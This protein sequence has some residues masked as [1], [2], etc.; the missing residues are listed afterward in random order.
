MTAARVTAVLSAP[1][2]VWAVLLVVAALLLI[3]LRSELLLARARAEIRAARRFRQGQEIYNKASWAQIVR[4]RRVIRLLL[5]DLSLLPIERDLAERGPALE[6]LRAPAEDL[7][8]WKDAAAQWL[9]AARNP[10]PDLP[11]ALAEP[12]REQLFAARDQVP[13]GRT[14]SSADLRAITA[15]LVQSGELA[16]L[17]RSYAD[18]RAAAVERFQEQDPAM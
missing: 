16:T 3:V 15:Y 2:P 18:M 10:L 13:P 5:A 1:A 6:T 17:R 7:P 12:T 8:L 4:S 14:L 9:A 11:D